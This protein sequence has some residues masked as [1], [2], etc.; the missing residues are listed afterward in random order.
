MQSFEII[1]HQYNVVLLLLINCFFV[2]V[3]SVI[4][5]IFTPSF[6]PL[7]YFCKTIFSPPSLKTQALGDNG[8]TKCVIIDTVKIFR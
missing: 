1:T 8:L 7:T 3:V 6:S 5:I 4:I 2:V